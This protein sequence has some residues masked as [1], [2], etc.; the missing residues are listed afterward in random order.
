MRGFFFPE[1]RSLKVYPC[2]TFEVQSRS[3]TSVPIDNVLRQPIFRTVSGSK[4]YSSDSIHGCWAHWVGCHYILRHTDEIKYGLRDHIQNCDVWALVSIAMHQFW[5]QAVT[6]LQSPHPVPVPRVWFA[7][8]STGRVG[9]AIAWSHFH[10]PSPV[11]VYL[12]YIFLVMLNNRSRLVVR[13]M[14]SQSTPTSLP[15]K[16]RQVHGADNVEYL[17]MLWKQCEQTYSATTSIRLDLLM[18]IANEPNFAT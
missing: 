8:T 7:I 14:A 4:L 17:L 6:S 1:N 12:S 2:L 3:T 13:T 15:T 18:R 11:L 10:V 16:T 5:R 9:S